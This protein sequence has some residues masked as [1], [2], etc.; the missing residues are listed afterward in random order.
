MS[1]RHFL[2]GAGQRNSYERRCRAM[3]QPGTVYGIEIRVHGIGDHDLVSELPPP[4][5]ELEN[6]I[7]IREKPD[8][9]QHGLSLINWSR[10]N[11]KL[12]H[13]I[14]WYLAFP[15]TM[16][17]LAG[18]MEPK[19]KVAGKTFR[20]GIAL[21]SVCITVAMAAW[22]TVIL[23]TVTH[24]FGNVANSVVL[25]LVIS[26]VGPV[27]LSGVIIYRRYSRRFQ[28]DV[29]R[30]NS[31]IS[32]ISVVALGGLFA[33][34]LLQVIWQSILRQPPLMLPS[35]WLGRWSGFIDPMTLLVAGTTAVVWVVA[36]LLALISLLVRF[37]HCAEWYMKDGASLS[38]AALLIVSA[39]A[40]L[41]GAGSAVRLTVAW[42][43][44]FFFSFQTPDGQSGG[45][46]TYMLL[47]P[48]GAQEAL[49]I[50]FIPL[51]LLEFVA[52]VLVGLILVL[53]NSIR[54][55]TEHSKFLNRGMSADYLMPDEFVPPDKWHCVVRD[56]A[57]FL[58]WL[59]VLTLPLIAGLWICLA[60]KLLMAE[61]S[62]I[63]DWLPWLKIGAVMLVLVLASGRPAAFAGWLTAIF[64]RIADIA[65]F[66]PPD[67]HPLAGVPYLNAL[68]DGIRDEVGKNGQNAVAL[69]GHSQGS[70]VCAWFVAWGLGDGCPPK[71]TEFIRCRGEVRSWNPAPG[72][73]MLFTCGAPLASLYAT[74]FPV[75]FS[76][77]LFGR[78]KGMCRAESW[79]N[80]WRQTDPIASAIEVAHNVNV[81]QRWEDVEWREKNAWWKC[82]RTRERI[83]KKHGAYFEDSVQQ[84]TIADNLIPASRPAPPQTF[85]P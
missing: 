8:I 2:L 37:K 23:E 71:A 38:A 25:Q 40:L 65:G 39:I 47:Q 79:Y 55:A 4:P 57:A 12:T 59:A 35:N 44:Q 19:S 63:A 21:S 15:F 77:E 26:A 32:L 17:N 31:A 51:F 56:A 62:T 50:D 33:F 78:I 76:D 52:V 64:G 73:V 7:S 16:V 81:T 82:R 10:A 61:D 70:I 11:R 34:C 27:T 69:V 5:R 24:S 49:R 43:F 68:V 14:L 75:Y 22:S 6:R 45:A 72:Q 13:N 42:L 28:D 53:F 85:G 1:N 46:T 67:L 36:L 84:T 80:F 58:P 41:H 66:W 9:P 29:T 20:V 83:P 54:L 18:Y 60:W 74:F 30:A 48:K 3:G